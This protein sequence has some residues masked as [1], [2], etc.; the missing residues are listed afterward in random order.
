MSKRLKLRDPDELAGI[1]QQL[2]R[3]ETPQCIRWLD[4][5]WDDLTGAC[6][7]L[8][9]A[10]SE[11]RET[12]GPSRTVLRHFY[13]VELIHEQIEGEWN[14]LKGILRGLPIR[15]TWTVPPPTASQGWMGES[16]R[17]NTP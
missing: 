5:E 15:P 9:L 11:G 6:G 10:W 16:P 3:S 7:D 17:S 8:F 2:R 13:R 14:E 12:V 4:A 1:L